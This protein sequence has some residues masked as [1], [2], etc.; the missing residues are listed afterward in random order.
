MLVSRS[1]ALFAVT[2]LLLISFVV[3]AVNLF[4]L[5]PGTIVVH[6]EGAVIPAEYASMEI[7]WDEEQAAV[8]HHRT[9][10]IGN[11]DA[12]THG[13][14]RLLID[15]DSFMLADGRYIADEASAVFVQ[16]EH[17]HITSYIP[18][19]SLYLLHSTLLI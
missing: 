16:E 5:V 18:S 9:K 19:V 10:C 14:L 4:Y 15:H 3:D 13:S 6:T 2:W 17:I 1:K 12:A 8:E 11:D 7:A